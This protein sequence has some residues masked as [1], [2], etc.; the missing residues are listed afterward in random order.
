M[1]ES[2]PKVFL[3]R[4]GETEWSVS[5]RHTGRNDIPLTPR[6]EESARKLGARLRS[7]TFAAVFCSPLQRARRTCEL[8][9]FGAAARPLPDLMEWN[10]GQYEGLKSSEIHE[11]RPDWRLFRDGCPGGEGPQDVAA[12]A[13][14]ILPLLRSAGGDVI[15][16]SHGHFL[17]MLMGRWMGFAA[18]DAARFGLDAA[19]LSVLALDPHTRDPMI[20]HWNDTSHLAP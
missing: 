9:G 6:G 17:R 13:D 11:R 2:L 12:R 18:V 4:H 14:R 20:D 8:A 10:Y 7:R 19:S 3:A 1:S 15:V 16:F 5:G